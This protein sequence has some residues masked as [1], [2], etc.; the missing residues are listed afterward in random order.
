MEDS[1]AQR[2][3]K[4]IFDEITATPVADKEKI[5]EESSLKRI[6][7]ERKLET[8]D[9]SFIV[10]DEIGKQQCIFKIPSDT[11][12]DT[13]EGVI[14]EA[15]DACHKYLPPIKGLFDTF[16]SFCQFSDTVCKLKIAMKL[17]TFFASTSVF[18]QDNP[19]H[20]LLMLRGTTV[21]TEDVSAIHT[22]YIK[23]LLK[24]ACNGGDIQRL[25]W[26][27]AGVCKVLGSAY[28]H[29][30]HIPYS[31]LT[32]R[33]VDPI[34]ILCDILV[35]SCPLVFGGNIARMI[36]EDERKGMMKQL[37]YWHAPKFCR[38]YNGEGYRWSFDRPAYRAEA[39]EKSR[40]V[41]KI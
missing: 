14:Y 3:P 41:F 27:H 24:C 17:R 29:S 7:L 37:R 20:L 10:I 2:R 4:R 1:F 13:P 19:G 38:D 9:N 6:R 12:L 34:S 25:L 39:I 21:F 30:V 40:N 31:E 5:P 15:V 36:T 32:K 11:K 18:N 8:T 33:V 22:A 35:A 16:M 28:G 26:I 23:A